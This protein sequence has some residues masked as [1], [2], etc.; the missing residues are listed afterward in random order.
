MPVAGSVRLDVIA[1]A[2]DQVN[3]VLKQVNRE[4]ERTRGELQATGAVQT[5]LGKAVQAQIGHLG[6]MGQALTSAADRAGGLVEKLG[7]L[8]GGLV[9]LG[10]AAGAKAV[11]E[12]AQAG[13]VVDAQLSRL[14]PTAAEAKDRLA[15]LQ[16]AAGGVFSLQ[17]L[18]QFES[19]QR[20][21]GISIGLT[22]DELGKLAARVGALGKDGGEALSSLAFDLATG[23]EA[24]LEQVGI[25]RDLGLAYDAAA[26]AAGRSTE[27]LTSA[28]KAAIGIQVL[29]EELLGVS[30]AGTESLSAF[31]R[32]EAGLKDTLTELQRAFAPIGALLAPVGEAL[33]AIARTLGAVLRPA[34]ALVSGALGGLLEV[35]VQVLSVVLKPIEYAARLASTALAGLLRLVGADG[36]AGQLDTLTGRQDAAAGAAGRHADALADQGVVARDT[37]AALKKL[38]SAV[39]ALER[40]Q[41]RAADAQ[42]FLDQQRI[43]QLEQ[44]RQNVGSLTDAQKEELATLKG[45]EAATKA[46]ASFDAQRQQTQESIGEL[47]AQEEEARR[48]IADLAKRAADAREAE[49]QAERDRRRASEVDGNLFRITDVKAY[50]A[51][52]EALA[53]ARAESARLASMQEKARGEASQ[54]TA[55]IR[56]QRAQADELAAAKARQVDQERAAAEVSVYAEEVA[57]RKAAADRAAAAAAR[58]RASEERERAAAERE[59]ARAAEALA[60]AKAELAARSDQVVRDSR[61]ELALLREE[62]PARRAVIERNAE[63]ARIQ[64]QLT[65]GLINQTAAAAQADVVWERYRQTVSGIEEASEGLGATVTRIGREVGAAV[66]RVSTLAPEMM[67]VQQAVQQ[68]TAAWVEFAAANQS[69]S[70]D[71]VKAVSATAGAIGAAAASFIEDTRLQAGIMAAFEAA[72][73]IASFASYD[74]V[75]GAAHS[76]AAVAFTAIA[77]GA[78]GSKASVPT[79]AA[80]GGG[81][82]SNV[83]RG[84][85]GGPTA[86]DDGFGGGPVVVNFT[87]PGLVLGTPQEVGRAAAQAA[88]SMR[89][90]GTDRR[91]F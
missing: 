78:G 23:S 65:E 71:I 82:R 79:A 57:E 67:A 40:A 19:T 2:Q 72:Q 52:E 59:A 5:D 50:K 86:G 34:V 89:G 43:R 60:K 76:A 61:V 29:K 24:A 42:L 55:A 77:A 74:Y 8:K 64:Q 13:A 21:L 31:Q 54:L 73:A 39:D 62:D 16:A 22:G 41:T 45:R 47:T 56:T 3:R 28:E 1:Q 6:R 91:R 66:N 14:G 90:T 69:G 20:E 81:G 51:A 44:I 70:G 75:A 58:A 17:E 68:S 38:G 15:E 10:A 25:A 33:A 30:A 37:Q 9:A 46:A 85:F 80:G 7:G 53:A 63:L 27:T 12:L 88:Q 32:L 26:E 87:N 84:S 18:A 4:L 11:Y 83:T 35:G 49:A 36:L 48:R